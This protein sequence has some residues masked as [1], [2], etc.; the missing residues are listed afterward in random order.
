MD[1][2]IQNVY[3]DPAFFAG[4]KNLRDTRSGLNE[5]LEQPALRA[6]LPDLEGLA[7]LELGCGM[8]QFARFCAEQ[9]GARR[10]VGV[11]V[12]ERM[13]EVAR[14]ENAHERVAYLHAPIETVELPESSFD[15]AVSS[16]ALH[17]V[18]DYP[19][20]VRRVRSWLKPGG[21]FLFSVEHPLVTAKA[22]M[23]GWVRDEDG[24]KLYWPV[25]D[26]AAEGR[27][28]QHWFVDGVVKYHRRISTLLNGLIA[29][30]FAVERVEEPEATAEALRERPELADESRRPPFLLVRAKAGPVA[31]R[32]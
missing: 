12:S 5:V 10:V 32:D 21:L 24:R 30:G 1:T 15:L 13:L 8:G 18:A 28:E 19:A 17:Y 4:Y 23:D 27:R 11:E 22:E 25:D 14:R 31:R 2:P 3:D 9:G 29:A 6:L 16:L 7:V 20:A 26:Y